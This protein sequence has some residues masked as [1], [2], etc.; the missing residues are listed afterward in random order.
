[1]I[2]RELYLEK[3]RA[4]IDKPFIKVITGIR[5]CG[6]ST[7]LLM[8]KEELLNRGIKIDNIIYIN[9][10]SMEYMDITDEKELYNYIKMKIKNQ[11]KYYIFLDEIQEVKG[12]EIAV[13]SFLIDFNV[14]I[15]ITGSNSKLLSSE[16]ATYIAGRYV[17]INVSTLSFLEAIQFKNYFYKD[18]KIDIHRGFLNYVRKGGFPVIHTFDYAYED[19]YKIINDIYASVILRDVIERNRI[20]NVEVLE[21]IIKFVFENI[22]NNFSAKKV[23]DYFKSQQRKVDIETVYN[24][25]NALESA[26]I[27]ERI[28]RYDLKGKE[29]LQTNEKYYIADIGLKYAVMG[30]RDRDISG[31]LEN[32]VLLELKRK[33]YKVYVG[34][35]EDKEV[36]F[37]GEKREQKIYVQVAF[38]LSS[39]ETVER[40]FKPLLS[41]KDHYP[42]YVVTM[43][44][45]W[46][47]NIEG[48]KH[49]NIA[50]FLLMDEYF[51]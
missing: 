35:M 2:K 29:V 1:M 17:E 44:E 9:F 48:V 8:I 16:L 7:V 5:R 51:L 3:I 14:D 24:Y 22:G 46:Q 42:K 43:E 25:L 10:E 27:I 50:D 18:E 38:R 26:F 15:Y 41:I 20:R 39:Q 36:D 28:P 31:I 45:F 19:A 49:K 13:N 40:E 32:I 47:D 4:F 34:K 23:A 33:G 6:K 12:W 30:Y 37:I 11:E 21:R